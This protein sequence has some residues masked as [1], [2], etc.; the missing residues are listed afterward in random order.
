MR[1]ALL[2][3]MAIALLPLLGIAQEKKD[4]PKPEM[5]SRAFEVKPGNTD[6]IMDA[7]RNLIGNDGAKADRT[8]GVVVVRAPKELMP[9]LEQV[10]KRLDAS[11]PGPTIVELTI[12]ALLASQDGAA[13]APIPPELQPVIAQLKGV[14]AYQSFHVLDVML[15]RSRVGDWVSATGVLSLPSEKETPTDSPSYSAR[16]RPNILSDGGTRS[17]RLDE[18]TFETRVRMPNNN[19]SQ[20]SF[21]GSVDVKDGQKVV[22]GKTGFGGGQRA[23]IL[24]V[25]GKIV[26]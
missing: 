3:V 21:R 22:V 24:V 14:F 15:L 10:V 19:Y 26:D 16:L 1:K 4:E 5:T 18:L 13:A 20:V 2:V 17:I 7:I 8:A 11:A 25:V 23:L 9:A 12:Y 6:R